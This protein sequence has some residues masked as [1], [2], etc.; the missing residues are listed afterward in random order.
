MTL[1]NLTLVLIFAVATYFC[2]RLVEVVTVYEYQKG[3]LYQKG[4]FQ[5]TLGAGRYYY[6]KDR[7]SIAV[8]DT[9]RRLIMLPGQEI[10]TKDNVSLK[11]SLAGF[12]EVSDPVKAQHQSENYEKE[13]YT[14]SQLVL[15]DLVGKF[16]IDEFLE[17]SD[18]INDQ[19]FI[20]VSDSATKL[21]LS[22]STLAVKDTMLPGNLKRAFSSILEAQKDAQRQ[23]EKARGEQAVLRSLAN[24]SGLYENNPMLLQARLVQVLSNG[25][26]NVVF[27]ADNKVGMKDMLKVS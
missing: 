1:E 11:I 17:K 21:G 7:S 19:L 26:N 3:L 25:T 13:L 27:N 4:S 24:S 2:S 20:G 23:L 12:Y 8:I 16:T 14:I 18:E 5:K 9:R 10:L 15:R 6:L 22:V